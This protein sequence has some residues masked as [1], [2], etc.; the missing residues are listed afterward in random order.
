MKWRA[1]TST[2]RSTR[3]SA[4]DS[5]PAQE[6]GTTQGFGIHS[7]PTRAMH[8][9]EQAGHGPVSCPGSGYYDRGWLTAGTLGTMQGL[10]KQDRGNNATI[11]VNSP[12]GPEFERLLGCGGR[13]N[14]CGE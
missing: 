8:L 10:R 7:T 4:S 3:A 6:Q 14:L 12:T 13:F 11:A 9:D 2:S 1:C 5:N